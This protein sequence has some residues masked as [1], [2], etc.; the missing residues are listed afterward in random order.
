[1]Q[2]Q[3]KMSVTTQTAYT[4]SNICEVFHMENE[5]GGGSSTALQ[6]FPGIYLLHSDYHMRECH[7]I[8]ND[9][10]D[11][12]WLDFCREGRVEWEIAKGK[13]V[14]LESGNYIIDIRAGRE[15]TLHFPMRH[16]HGTS[17]R[18]HMKEANQ[19][20]ADFVKGIHV[21]VYAIRDKF[22]FG[23]QPFIAKGNQIIHHIFEE[24]EQVQKSISE[25]YYKIK[26]LVKYW[27]E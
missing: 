23:G 18:I 25:E 5:T 1:M 10:A 22:C 17:L 20:L 12:L 21:D 14:Y 7:T 8:K 24:I 15:F 2:Y 11:I 19:S 3:G 26:V 27:E 4:E 16:Y 9:D 6:V 13:Y